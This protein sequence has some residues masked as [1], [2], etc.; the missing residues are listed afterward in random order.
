MILSDFF[1]RQTHDD[2]DPRDVIPISFNMHNTLH[3]KYYKLFNAEAFA[4]KIMQSN[5]TR[6]PWCKKVL[7]MNLLPGKQ[8]V[9]LQIKKV[10]DNKPRLGQG[11]AGIRHRK[12][13]LMESLTA[14]ANKSCEIPNISTTQNEA[15]NRMDFPV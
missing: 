11:R 10:I 4:N 14:S 6:G 5:T 13:Q 2:S 15:K 1:S 7:D 8:K 3:E 12:P 9:V